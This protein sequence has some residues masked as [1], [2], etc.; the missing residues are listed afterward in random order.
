MFQ[1]TVHL[2]P[3]GSVSHKDGGATDM[4]L[5]VFVKVGAYSMVPFNGTV[6][7]GHIDFLPYKTHATI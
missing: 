5:A 4:A 2:P 7:A 1:H 3:S 6:A